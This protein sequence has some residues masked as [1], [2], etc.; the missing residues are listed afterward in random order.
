LFKNKLFQISF[1]SKQSTSY[2]HTFIACNY[3]KAHHFHLNKLSNSSHIQYS[4]QSS[5]L[6][7]TSRKVGSKQ[8]DKEWICRVTDKTYLITLLHYTATV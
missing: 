8:Y 1:S 2:Y 6:Y 7:D 5:D 3:I 4:L